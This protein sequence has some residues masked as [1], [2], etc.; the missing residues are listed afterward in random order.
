MVPVESLE[1]KSREELVTGRRYVF[2]FGC[3]VKMLK[4]LEIRA[5][6]FDVRSVRFALTSSIRRQ[7]VG[8]RTCFIAARYE[9]R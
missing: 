6:E 2:R 8:K 5:H 7:C 9:Q 3:L 1:W 4:P